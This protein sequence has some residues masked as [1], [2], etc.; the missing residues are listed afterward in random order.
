MFSVNKLLENAANVN[1]NEIDKKETD[2]TAKGIYIYIWKNNSWIINY[3][4]IIL[5][6]LRL[7]Y[8]IPLE[9]KEEVQ[10]GIFNFWFPFRR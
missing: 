8:I 4:D 10:L 6:C 7:E 2:V 1:I 5:H 9:L 3:T